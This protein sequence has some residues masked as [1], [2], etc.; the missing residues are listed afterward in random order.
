[1]PLIK[2]PKERRHLLT[3]FEVAQ[4]IEKAPTLRDKSII[5][6]YYITGIRCSEAWSIGKDDIWWD[7]ESLHLR[8]TR[9]KRSKKEVIP[10]P[11]ILIIDLKTPFIEHIQRQKEAT[12]DGKQVWHYAD[13]PTTARIYMSR[14]L[15]SLNQ[16]VWP[17]LFRH[18]RAESFRIKDFSDREL[19]AWFGW[20]DIRSTTKYTHPSEKTIKKMGSEIQ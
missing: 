14:M 11:S 5:A 20:K 16:D 4:M 3:Q 10:S 19:M 18:T 6:L 1:M 12:E 13:N 2:V 17:H 15:K 8:I 7:M 9:K